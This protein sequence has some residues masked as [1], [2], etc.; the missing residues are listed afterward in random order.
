MNGSLGSQFPCIS[1]LHWELHISFPSRVS[2]SAFRSRISS[3]QVAMC[4]HSSLDTYPWGTILLIG[5][6]LRI[7]AFQI[8][9]SSPCIQRSFGVASCFGICFVMSQVC[10]KCIL[11]LFLHCLALPNT[12][13]RSNH[14]QDHVRRTPHFESQDLRQLLRFA[15]LG[16]LRCQG[17]LRHVAAHR[18]IRARAQEVPPADDLIQ[19]TETCQGCNRS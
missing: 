4:R 16:W 3:K 12:L 9:S 15:L 14:H 7:K 11:H 17:R 5:P 13:R 10:H 18:T 19:G 1:S 8:N 2:V 6:L